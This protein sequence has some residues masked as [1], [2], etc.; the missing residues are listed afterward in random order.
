MAFGAGVVAVVVSYERRVLAALGATPDP[1]A[2]RDFSFPSGAVHEV[3]MPDGGSVFVAESGAGRPVLLLH[4]HGANLGIFALLAHGLRAEG[5]RVVALDQRGFG[6]SSPVPPAYGFAGLVD[7]AATVVEKL[8]L[9]GAIVVGHSLGGAVAL[10]LAIEH[11]E[12]IAAGRIAALVVM[13]SGAR[14]PANRA[15]TR[16]WATASELSVLERLSRHPR[17]GTVLSR[18][19]FGVDAK[20]SHVR[21]MRAAGFDSPVARRR[22][23]TLRLLGVDLVD[24]LGEIDVPVLVMTGEL[25][26]VVSPAQSRVLA[27]GLRDGRLEVYP[28][29]GHVLPMERAASLTA[30]IVGLA[31]ELDAA[32]SQPSP[33]QA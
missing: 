2:E 25:D 22:G 5:L 10:A 12:L 24:R 8:D 15:W 11:R 29:A 7:D 13:S 4:G 26:R 18:T 20:A 3:V 33:V 31:H 6:R 9:H 17:H 30:A 28:G 27:D 19:N 1:D 32:D 16:A 14:G 23:F 21:A